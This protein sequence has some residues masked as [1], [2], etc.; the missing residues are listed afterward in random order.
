MTTR[1]GLVAVFGL[2]LLL[3]PARAEAHAS[4]VSSGSY[5]RTAAGL[6]AELVFARED[7]LLLRAALDQ[8]AD[9]ALEDA[10]LRRD[11]AIWLEL[12]RDEVAV[13]DSGRPC[14]LRRAQGGPSQQ[15]GVTLRAQYE[16]ARPGAQL[17][18]SLGIFDRLAPGHRHIARLT[19]SGDSVEEV[20]S[21]AHRRFE[22]S[23][24]T[25]AAMSAA[26]VSG[27]STDSEL[28]TLLGFVKMGFEHILSGADHIAFLFALLLGTERLR[29]LLSV[30]T[31]F[32]LAHSLTLALVAL[33]LCSPQTTLVECAIALSVAYVGIEN[34]RRT[35]Q[36]TRWR[37]ALVFG[38][39]H[40][41]GFAGAL[42][43]AA[44]PPFRMTEALLGFNVGVELG[45]LL[46][47]AACLPA[48]LWLRKRAAFA[49]RLMPALS[50][51]VVI[52]GLAWFAVRCL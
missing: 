3:L 35:R 25:G 13:G 7:A 36:E 50:L 39:V 45:Q 40:G 14:A 23:P 42:T 21:A 44:L 34:L 17:S 46:L 52:S 22:S 27:A 2:S 32:T 18:V 12:L 38:L 43:E 47:L 33:G 4:G 24:E 11:D 8:N 30:I 16:C 1:S 37:P 49:E 41:F 10:E 5:Q 15:N 51:L 26:G 20:L 31:A 28:T 6:E 48:L 9:G 29:P 19:S